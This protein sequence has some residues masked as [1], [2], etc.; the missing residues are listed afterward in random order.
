MPSPLAAFLPKTRT[1][2]TPLLTCIYKL[3]EFA[4]ISIYILLCIKHNI[5]E[6]VAIYPLHHWWIMGAKVSGLQ[7]AK[8]SLRKAK[9]SKSLACEVCFLLANQEPLH[10]KQE[11]VTLT[12]LVL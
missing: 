3:A 6:C 2:A 4:V 5:G 7:F 1:L 10:Q 12:G 8:A 11:T 9:L